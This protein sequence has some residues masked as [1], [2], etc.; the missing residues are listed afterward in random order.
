MEVLA[1]SLTVLVH[2]IG[3]GALVFVI[4]HN[5]GLDWRSWWPGDDDGGG[6]DGPR[7]PEDPPPLTD[8]APSRARLREPGR[9]ADAYPPARRRPEHGPVPSPERAPREP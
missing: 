1:L 8:S 3:L 9:I 4:V 7:A 5:D 2:F 6:H